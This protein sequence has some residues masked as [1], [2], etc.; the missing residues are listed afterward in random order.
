MRIRFMHIVDVHG[1]ILA[2]VF[3][4]GAMVAAATGG[5]RTTPDATGA[6]EGYC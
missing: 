3:V 5:T 1:F 4:A 2:R 6:E